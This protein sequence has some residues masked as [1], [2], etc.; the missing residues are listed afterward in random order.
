MNTSA[1]TLKHNIVSSMLEAITTIEAS[2]IYLSSA[3]TMVV[4]YPYEAKALMRFDAIVSLNGLPTKG[5]T[6]IGTSASVNFV[7]KEFV[8]ANGFYKN[9]KSDHKLAIRVASEQRISTIKVFYPSVF[10]I[11]GHEATDL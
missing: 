11:D 1:G 9:C 6:R 3:T 8:M 2:K 4:M 5:D 10:T 7:I